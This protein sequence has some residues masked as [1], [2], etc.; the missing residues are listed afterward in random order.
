MLKPSFLPFLLLGHFIATGLADGG[1]NL[2][3]YPIGEGIGGGLIAPEG[4][5]VHGGFVNNDE[6][7]L[8][9]TVLPDLPKST[10]R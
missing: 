10:H 8:S 1:E 5:L 2:T 3:G 6:L 4:K 9:A 7:L